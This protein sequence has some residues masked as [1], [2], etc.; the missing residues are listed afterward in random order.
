MG[1]TPPPPPLRTKFLARKGLRIWGVPPPSPFTDKIRKVVFDVA[2]NCAVSKA[3]LLGILKITTAF[4]L[5]ATMLGALYVT[6]DYF[7]PTIPPTT[8]LLQ[9]SLSPRHSGTTVTQE[10]GSPLQYQC[11]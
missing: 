7:R 11:N 6:M 5:L 9:F 4:L 10:S 2:P 8:F 1:G 3:N